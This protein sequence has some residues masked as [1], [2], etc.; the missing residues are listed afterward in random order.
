M[1]PLRYRRGIPRLSLGMTLS[2]RRWHILRCARRR[3]NW[4]LHSGHGDHRFRLLPAD[5]GTAKKEKRQ[6]GPP[7]RSYHQSNNSKDCSTNETN[8]A[9][10]LQTPKFP[11]WKPKQTANYLSAI[12]WKHR[13]GY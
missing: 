1:E 10:D 7:N 12:K 5:P 13:Q 3:W 8:H 6:N 4:Y 11:E 9:R 2:R